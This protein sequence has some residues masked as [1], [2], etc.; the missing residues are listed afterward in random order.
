M[1]TPMGA[2]LHRAK[3]QGFE[4]VFDTTPG[5]YSMK[6]LEYYLRFKIEKRKAREA[7]QKSVAE[8]IDI[9][10]A[11]PNEAEREMALMD[12]AFMALIEKLRSLMDDEDAMD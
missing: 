9:I 8:W 5:S 12:E 10:K 2:M 11:M 6:R 7:A 4:A 1:S 3:D